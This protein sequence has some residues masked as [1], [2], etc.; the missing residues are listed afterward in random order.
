VLQKAKTVNE[1]IEIIRGSARRGLSAFLVLADATGDIAMVEWTPND[2]A[3]Y[4]P[5]GDWFGQANHARAEKMIKYDQYRHPDSF[6]RRAAMEEAVRR[7]LG[8]LTPE[9]AIQILRDRTGA[10]FA[11]EPSVANPNVLNPV[12]VHPASRTLW[13]SITMQPHA[14]FGAFVPFTFS[15]SN[16]PT[17]PA[18]EALLNG[19]LDWERAEIQVA[20]HALELHHSRKY[21][22]ARKAWN[23]LLDSKP[24]TLNTRRLALG[25]ALTLNALKD[26]KGAYAALEPAAEAE[27]PFDVRAVALVSRGIL[28]GRLGRRKEASSQFDE[29]L[30]HLISHPEFTAFNSL[31]ETAKQGFAGS[32][33]EAALPI[34]LYDL[35]LP[36]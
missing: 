12:V 8:E 32:Q 30:R 7:H 26:Y 29:A 2:M 16:P 15:D 28:A 27:A 1:A 20:R 18:S 17:F 31:K 34:S 24:K 21:E 13:H 6:Q 14:P 35:G 33:T 10:A 19:S 4:R 3:V 25:Y 9:L 22:E 5:E 23:E 36:L 11:N